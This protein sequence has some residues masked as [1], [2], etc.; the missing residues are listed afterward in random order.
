MK[1]SVKDVDIATGGPHII[2]LNENDARMMDLHPA[3]RIKAIKGRRSTIAVVDYAESEKTIPKGSAGLFEEVLDAL[4]AKDKDTI[5]IKMEKKPESIRLIRKKLDGFELNKDEI[6]TIIQDI[7]DGKVTEIELT[8]YVAANYTRGMSFKETVA[9]TKAM[10]ET[11]ERLSFNKKP[12]VDKHCIGGVPG[13]RTTMAVIP[14]LVAAGLTVPKT[15]SRAITSPAGTA[16]TMEVLCNVNLSAKDITRTVNKTG[17]CITWGGAVN[18][19]PADDTII[20]V[21]HPLSIDAEGQLLASIMAKKGSVSA[22]H[23]LID[24]PVGRGAK[25]ESRKRAEHLK[26]MFEKVGNALG[27]KTKVAITDGKEPI[28]NGIGPA[29]EARDVMW[30]LKN[31]PRGPKDLKNK[32]I[33]LAGIIFEFTGKARHGEGAKLAEELIHTGKAYEKMWEMIKA[34]GAKIRK[35]DD[36]KPANLKYDYKAVK[37]GTVVSIDN[38]SIARIARVAGC[39]KDVYSGLFLYKHVGDKVEEG[40]KLFT[41]Y[42]QNHTKLRYAVETL[43]YVDGYRVR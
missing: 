23:V 26:D 4:N 8:Y 18:L 27:M 34:Q 22:T 25:I 13:N 28:G 24:I 11:G 43:G 36:I 7:T 42:S 15:S 39:P 20:N 16:D 38:R 30:M 6:K 2:I 9:L 40:E 35:I 14:I 5:H 3:D 12:I 17:G 1:L 37:S 10:I 33:K 32:C 19:A 21:E 41:I 31:D 29:L